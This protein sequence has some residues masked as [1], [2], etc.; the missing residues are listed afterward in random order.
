MSDVNPCA[1]VLAEALE[2]PWALTDEMRAVLANLLARRMVGQGVA[3]TELEAALA[4]RTPPPTSDSPEVALIPI[5]GVIAP[6]MNLLTEMSGGASFDKLTADLH[7]AVSLQP[8][9]IV[10]D[11]DSPGG[12]VAGAEEFAREVL[13]ARTQVPVIAQSNHLMASAAY[14]VGS[15]ATEIV[16]SPSSLVGSIGVYTL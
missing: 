7:E 16:A 12:N 9:A 15:C 3:T 1:R 5:H 14:W 11:I 2:H 8:K 10:L 6:R 4:R 13:K